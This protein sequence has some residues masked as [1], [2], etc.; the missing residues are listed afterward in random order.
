MRLYLRA[1]SPILYSSLGLGLKVC[2]TGIK[3]M[4]HPIS[5]TTSVATGIKGV[6]YHN[7]VCKADQWDCFTL[8][9]SGSLYLLKYNWNAT[10]PLGFSILL[11][12]LG[13]LPPS[14]GSL[15]R[16][17]CWMAGAE[18]TC[19]APSGSIDCNKGGILLGIPLC[20]LWICFIIIG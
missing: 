7:L 15:L 9:S 11:Q 1:L 5:M 16:D 6:C 20:M 14:I 3:G 13:R 10:I 4:H 18:M 12:S 8:R 19:R 2:T 17:S